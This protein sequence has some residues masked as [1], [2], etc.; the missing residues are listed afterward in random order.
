[1]AVAGC[2]SDAT[3]LATVRPDSS[4]GSST[5]GAGSS[6]SSSLFGG[7]QA[8]ASVQVPGDL[9][10]VTTTWQ[11]DADGTCRETL[12]TASLAITDLACTWTST[13]TEITVTFANGGTLVMQ[14]SIAG[15]SHDLLVLDGFVYQRQG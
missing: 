8:V 12:V 5:S 4:V 6:A 3:G 15:L 10:T 14:F 2:G 7:W 11:F 9:Q 13:D 1:M